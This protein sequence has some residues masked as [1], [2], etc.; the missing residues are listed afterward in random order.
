MTTPL[1]SVVIPH[2]AIPRL[3]LRCVDSIPQ[4]PDVEV[5]VVDDCSPD[6]PELQAA[7]A[8][9][10]Q[11]PG[12]TLCRT[13]QGGS[14]GRAR[15]VG[16]DA[17]RGRW[18]LFADA[19]DFF[20]ERLAA[21]LDQMAGAEEDVVYFNFRSVLSDDVSQPSDRENSYNA[22]FQQYACDH[23]EDNFRFLYQTPWGKLVRRS[24]VEEHHIRFDETR[25]ANDALFAVRVGCEARA[26]RVVDV[27]LYILTERRGSLA[28]QFC[29]KPGETAVRTK[30]ALRVRQTIAAHG[31]TFSYDY[32]IFVRLLLWNG[33]FRDL[34]HIYH[35]ITRYGLTKRSLLAIVWH[36]GRRFRPL[37]L[38]LTA[39][40]AWLTLLRK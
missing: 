39:A 19:D 31:Y 13:P 7:L 32:Q 30:V 34:L 16:L 6:T 20:D 28:N 11:R 25:Y 4:R 18:L 12:L 14:A 26:I 27:P 24:L 35:T 29:R 38:W 1:F 2:Y 37:C 33:E 9:L 10:R 21:F 40:D 8:T 5:V 22:F 15:N 17:A 3:L 23:R 36:T